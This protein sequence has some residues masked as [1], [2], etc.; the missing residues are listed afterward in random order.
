[1]K[2]IITTQ[3]GS[4]KVLKLTEADKPTPKANE[5]LIQIK[6]SSVTAA[7]SMMRKGEPYYGRLFIGLTKPKNPVPGTGFSGIVVSAGKEVSAFSIGDAVFGEIVLGPGTNCEYA[8]R[9]SS[10]QPSSQGGV[11]NGSDTTGSMFGVLK[12][13]MDV[14]VPDFVFLEQLLSLLE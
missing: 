14:L 3:Y 2:T 12:G 5:I 6:A 10:A 4:P 7:D 1:M 9:M 13:T 8:S 11:A